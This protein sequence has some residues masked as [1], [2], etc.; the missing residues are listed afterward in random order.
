LRPERT[1]EAGAARRHALAAHPGAAPPAGV[2]VTARLAGAGPGGF[3]CEFELTADATR[4]RVPEAEPGRRADGL[5]RHTCFEAFLAAEGAASY[6]EFNFSP[7]G[8]WAA[9]RF[10]GYRAGMRP[11]GLAAPPRLAVRR[12]AGGLTLSAQVPL[13]GLFASG[14][15]VRVALAAVLEDEGG[16]L[17]YWA[18]A[19]APGRPDFHHAAGFALA[20][21]VP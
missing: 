9:Y 20:A 8:D 10:D 7:G 1:S 16:A 3:G 6:C 21:C 18:L 5:W 14:S 19:H 11:A 2:A 4:I 13:A 17:S 15:A 12:T